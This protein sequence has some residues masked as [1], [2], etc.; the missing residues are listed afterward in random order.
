MVTVNYAYSVQS[1]SVTVRSSVSSPVSSVHSKQATPSTAG[2]S[3]SSSVTPIH[4]RIPHPLYQST[5][6]ARALASSNYVASTGEKKLDLASANESAEK[7]KGA[8]SATSSNRRLCFV[9]TGLVP[10]QIEDVKKLALRVNGRYVTNFDREVTHV[11]VTVNADNGANKTLKYLQGV[12]YRKWIVSYQWVISCLAQKRLVNEEPY[13]A[14]DCGTRE[15]GPR[16]SRLR[17]KGL[18]EGFV[19]LCLGPY[20]NVS[21]A[22][23]EVG[24]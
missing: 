24:N 23:Y 20:V 17:Q 15:A 14:V 2:R 7:Q 11:I 1:S 13:E 8:R 10:S 4:K 21:V 9:C 16:N 22:Q 3:S 12:A 6:K 19:F 5:P 18:F